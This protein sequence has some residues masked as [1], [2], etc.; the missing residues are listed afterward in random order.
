M[1]WIIVALMTLFS[2]AALYPKRFT[3][4]KRIDGLYLV[5]FYYLV[6]GTP[7]VAVSLINLATEVISRPTVH[8]LPISTDVVYSC[9]IVCILV[10]A[11]GAGIHSTSTSVS[12]TFKGHPKSDA[13]LTNERFHLGLSHHMG[14]LGG[15]GTLLCLFLLEL[16]HPTF[17]I[18][19][20]RVTILIGV[21]L[22]VITGN[23]SNLESFY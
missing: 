5:Q 8:L 12:Q 14:Y 1:Q 21:M 15:I 4:H 13:Y 2:C 7:I 19:D 16:N 18:F 10:A 6:I 23:I 11:I 17:Q 20:P 3:S 9:Y 22:G